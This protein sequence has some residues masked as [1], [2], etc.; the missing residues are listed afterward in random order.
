ME[1]VRRLLLHVLPTGFVRIRHYGILSNRHRHENLA[2]CRQLLE[3]GTASEAE[4]R[5][6]EEDAREGARRSL[7]RGSVPV[8]GAGRMIVIEEFR[9][10]PPGEGIVEGVEAC[11]A[12]DSS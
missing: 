6:D 2:L 1:F 12:V 11:V 5:G 7:R 9:P 3:A 10:M 4:S 8:C